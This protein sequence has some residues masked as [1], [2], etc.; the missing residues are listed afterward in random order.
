MNLIE[1][2]NKD[3]ETNTNL[4]F[5]SIYFNKICLPG[6]NCITHNDL[7]QSYNTV[8]KKFNIKPVNSEVLVNFLNHP[9]LKQYMRNDNIISFSEF[10][11][12]IYISKKYY[13]LNLFTDIKNF[14]MGVNKF[15][16]NKKQI[17]IIIFTIIDL[18]AFAIT[19]IA[20]YNALNWFLLI[21]KSCA[22]LFLLNL[23]FILMQY[24]DIANLIPTNIMFYL[25][26]SKKIF[27]HFMF[28]YKAFV[29]AILHT[30]AHIGNILYV[31][32]KCNP[33]CTYKD[34]PLIKDKINTVKISWAYFNNKISFITGYIMIVLMIVLV[35][36]AIK[37]HYYGRLTNMLISHRIIVSTLCI[38]VIIHG[39]EQLLGF[40]F[41]Y[42]FVMPLFIIYI[43][44]R[45]PEYIYYNK[46]T[47][48]NWDI[49]KDNLIALWLSKTIGYTT[50]ENTR[51][52][53]ERDSLKA[54]S[55]LYLNN[56]NISK[57]E[58]HP[59]TVSTGYTINDKVL[60]INIVGKWT[61][62]LKQL[63]S[64][65]SVIANN[66]YFYYG[67]YKLSAFRF[68]IY[69]NT[70]IFICSNLGIT[71][72]ISL[73][74]DII[75]N[76][77]ITTKNY[78]IWSINNLDM[79]HL[80]ANVLNEINFTPKIKHL[81]IFIYY[82][83]KFNFAKADISRRDMLSFYYLHT[84]L[85]HFYRFDIV[86]NSKTPNLIIIGR[87]NLPNIFIRLVNKSEPHTKIG[88]F[89]CGSKR[90]CQLVN[91][92]TTAYSNNNKNVNIDF[93]ADEGLS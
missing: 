57:F 35:A 28:G 14:T 22:V 66:M 44:F 39:Y 63:L 55:A 65:E 50:L 76:G 85:H 90:Y 24:S 49:S 67:R 42:V 43:I 88:V 38:L 52:Y 72:Y 27:F 1:A 36:L 37:L 61:K 8:V 20:K 5:D 71:A 79:I 16:I 47:I 32:N 78:F 58:W 80:L 77:N 26:Y 45:I 91:S 81:R 19:I 6:K 69:Y 11:S 64:E 21:A 68:H 93:W 41:S 62:K 86:A 15:T 60:Y 70:K 59:F 54:S 46:L 34:V 51:N 10:K 87:L 82:S 75:M 33:N 17:C 12:T 23:S 92:F 56:P 9:R 73:M 18:I 25:P 89:V 48:S 2:L 3:D 84:L 83:N 74:K 29:Y 53:I 30:C 7:I 40:N 4:T 13:I 31:L